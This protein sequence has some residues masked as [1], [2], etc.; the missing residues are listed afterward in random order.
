M[1]EHSS[2]VRGL[3]QRI[4]SGIPT[5][6][7]NPAAPLCVEVHTGPAGMACVLLQKDPTASRHLPIASCLRIW[8]DKELLL[9]PLALEATAIQE[10]LSKL[11]HYT[12]FAHHIDLPCS[13]AFRMLMRTNPRLHPKLCAQ[14]LD[15]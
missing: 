15:I 2:C 5:L 6:N 10:S 9:S 1:P 8:G 11:A 13:D 7:F 12:A 14:L 3:C 4:L